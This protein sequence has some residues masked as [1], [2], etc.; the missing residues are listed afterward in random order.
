MELTVNGYKI[1]YK[2]TGSGEE[3]VVILQGWGTT[4]A[5]YD[6][7]AACINSKYRVIQL[8]LPGFGDSDEPREPLGRGRLRRLFR[9][10]Y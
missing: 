5:V 1:F 9:S 7:V 6:S 3:T 2:E 10:L 4:M 8:D